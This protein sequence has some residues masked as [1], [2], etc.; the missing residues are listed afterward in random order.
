[1]AFTMNY[2]KQMVP[3]LYEELTGEKHEKG[4]ITVISEGNHT[5]IVFPNEK[6]KNGEINEQT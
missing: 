4:T 2:L 3:K 5:E 1:M 6:E